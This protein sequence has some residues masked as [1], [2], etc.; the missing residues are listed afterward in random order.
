[1]IIDAHTHIFPDHQAETILQN[2]A[3]MFNVPTY[4]N[5]TA[6]DLL[7]KMDDCGIDYAVIHMVA[8]LPSGVQETNAWL[9]NLRQ[10]RL[11]K[12]GTLHPKYKNYA[13]E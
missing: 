1:M 6:S 12:F 2:T 9:M 11:I 3:R 10:D 7:S 13:D 8:P 4:G 5:A